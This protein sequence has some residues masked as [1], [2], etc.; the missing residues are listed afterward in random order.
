MELIVPEGSPTEEVAA[1]LD[2]LRNYIDQAGQDP[3]P[4]S[5]WE[6]YPTGDERRRDGVC[7]NGKLYY[8]FGHMADL[9][10]FA[11][12]E[13]LYLINGELL[14]NDALPQ[15]AFPAEEAEECPAHGFQ[16][17]VRH[18]ST[19]GADPYAVTI[20]ACGDHV[21]DLGDGPIITKAGSVHG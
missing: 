8:T 14:S 2:A 17:V 7:L 11:M 9:G 4:D 10:T 18:Y 19:R 20:L 15:S 12:V 3:G 16:K 5:E 13:S 1:L 6:I 21:M